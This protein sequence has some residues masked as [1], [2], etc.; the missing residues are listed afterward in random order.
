MVYEK[1]FTIR[2]TYDETTKKA[3]QQILSGTYTE[4]YLQDVADVK[5]EVMYLKGSE[6]KVTVENGEEKYDYSGMKTAKLWTNASVN[7]QS[8]MAYLE[9]ITDDKGNV[10]GYKAYYSIDDGETFEE[11]T[12]SATFEKQST[13]KG[14]VLDKSYSILGA[15]GSLFLYFEYDSDKKCGSIKSDGFVTKKG[16]L[17]DGTEIVAEIGYDSEKGG[18]YLMNEGEITKVMDVD[19]YIYEYGMY[20]YDTLRMSQFNSYE[21]YLQH[22]AYSWGVYDEETGMHTLDKDAVEAYIADKANG[23]NADYYA[24]M[25][26]DD[27]LQDH[28][29]MTRDQ[30]NDAKEKRQEFAILIDEEARSYTEKLSLS[31]ITFTDSFLSDSTGDSKDTDTYSYRILDSSIGINGLNITARMSLNDGQSITMNGDIEVPGG[32]GGESPKEV[33]RIVTEVHADIQGDKLTLSGKD[34]Q[35]DISFNGETKKEGYYTPQFNQFIGGTRLTLTADSHINS[36]NDNLQSLSNSTVDAGTILG[37][38]LSV[39]TN[40]ETVV[41]LKTDTKL[42][43]LAGKMLETNLESGSITVKATYKFNPATINDVKDG[44]FNANLNQELTITGTINGGQ[45]WKGVDVK[46][47]T[48]SLNGIELKN[49]DSVFGGTYNNGNIDMGGWFNWNGT[50]ELNKNISSITINKG[51]FARTCET[52]AGFV[53]SVVGIVVDPI[54]R[55]VTTIVTDIQNGTFGINTVFNAVNDLQTGGLIGGLVNAISSAIDGKGFG[56]GWN[57][58]FSGNVLLNWSASMMLNKSYSQVVADGDAGKAAIMGAVAV[59]AIVVTVCTGGL[60]LAAFI[61]A[62]AAATP[63]LTGAALVASAVITSYLAGT[64]AFNSALAFE[65]GDTLMGVMNAVAA[66]MTILFPVRIGG[67]AEGATAAANAASADKVVVHLSA[68]ERLAAIPNSIVTGLK[69]SVKAFGAL[70]GSQGGVAAFKAWQ[71]LAQHMYSMTKLNVGMNVIGAVFETFGITDAVDKWLGNGGFGNGW[72]GKLGNSVANAVFVES[73]QS[74][75]LIS[76]NMGN[77]VM[78]AGIMYVS[79]PLAQELMSGLSKTFTGKITI[80]AQAPVESLTGFDKFKYNFEHSFLGEQVGGFVEEQVKETVLKHG[81]VSLGMDPAVAEYFVEYLDPSGSVAL[82]NSMYTNFVNN[83]NYNALASSNGS[84]SNVTGMIDS[85]FALNGTT[86]Q[87]SFANNTLTITVNGQTLFISNITNNTSLQNAMLTLA[88][89]A[90]TTDFAK[91][92][93]ATVQAKV[94]AIS[95]SVASLNTSDVNTENLMLALTASVV[96]N[97]DVTA[98]QLQNAYQ[99]VSNYNGFNNLTFSQEFHGATELNLQTKV[100]LVALVSNYANANGVLDSSKIVADINAGNVQAVNAFVQLAVYNNLSAISG[101]AVNISDVMQNLDLSNAEANIINNTV[102]SLQQRFSS[103]IET[104]QNVPGE[105]TAQQRERLVALQDVNEALYAFT[106]GRTTFEQLMENSVVS[107]VIQQETLSFVSNLAYIA[108]IANN[109]KNKVFTLTNEELSSLTTQLETFVDNNSAIL[110]GAIFNL[111][112][113]DLQTLNRGLQA[114]NFAEGSALNTLQQKVNNLIESRTPVSAEEIAAAKVRNTEIQTVLDTATR[115]I[116]SNATTAE[117]QAGKVNELLRGE[118]GKYAA[119]N[120]LMSRGLITSGFMNNAGLQVLVEDILSGREIDINSERYSEY[121]TGYSSDNYMAYLDYNKLAECINQAVMEL[122]GNFR[123]YTG[124]KGYKTEGDNL[125]QYGALLSVLC[126]ANQ[127]IYAEVGFGKTFIADSIGLARSYIGKADMDLIVQNDS[128]LNNHL[129]NKALMERNG[130]VVY[131]MGDIVDAAQN[132]PDSI[133]EFNGEKMTAIE[134]YTRVMNDENGIRIWLDSQYGFGRTTAERNATEQDTR[135]QDVQKAHQARTGR[136]T[137]ADE[138]HKFMETTMSYVMSDGGN[139]TLRQEFSTEQ[140]EAMKQLFA[141]AN[142]LVEGKDFVVDTVNGQVS[143]TEAGM[144]SVREQISGI[145][146]ATTGKVKSMLQAMSEAS[147]GNKYMLTNN[148]ELVGEDAV[149]KLVTKGATGQAEPSMILSDFSYA[150]AA[151]IMCLTSNN[152]EADLRC[153]EEEAIERAFD[154]VRTSH[155]TYG[156]S[157]SGLFFGQGQY[158]GMSGTLSHVA[159]LSD[160]YGMTVTR[161]GTQKNF[162]FGELNIG[163]TRN[164]LEAKLAQAKADLAQAQTTTGA[165]HD[166]IVDAKQKVVEDLTAALQIF[167]TVTNNGTETD[168]QKVLNELGKAMQNKVPGAQMAYEAYNTISLQAFT[169]DNGMIDSNGAISD[170]GIDVIANNIL[171]GSATGM[172]QLFTS[173]RQ[174]TLDKIKARILEIANSENSGYTVSEINGITTI[175]SKTGQVIQLLEINGTTRAD[176]IYKKS[177][178]GEETGYILAE[179]GVTKI[180]LGNERS[181]MGL[182]FS[183]D[184]ALSTDSTDAVYS[185]LHQDFGRVGRH[186]GELFSRTVYANMSEIGTLLSDVE[187][188]GIYEWLQNEFRT[189]SEY[190]K[191]GIFDNIT[192]AED[193]NNLTDAQKLM[194][195]KM[196]KGFVQSS[197]SLMFGMIDTLNDKC[198]T[199][200]IADLMGEAGISEADREV[201]RNV[202]KNLFDNHTDGEATVGRG[203]ILSGKDQI[204]NSLES[205]RQKAIEAFSSLVT[206]LETD[207]AKAKAQQWLE[208]WENA[209]FDETGAANADGS[210]VSLDVDASSVQA[211]FDIIYHQADKVMPY[212]SS[213]ANGMQM[214]K[215]QTQQQLQSNGINET[216]L[217]DILNDNKYSVGENLTYEGVRLVKAYTKLKMASDDDDLARALAILL[218]ELLGLDFSGETGSSAIADNALSIAQQLAKEDISVDNLTSLANMGMITSDN[219]KVYRPYL[220][221]ILKAQY[222]PSYLAQQNIKLPSAMYIEMLKVRNELTTGKLR[223]NETELDRDKLIG[224]IGLN[225]DEQ[226]ILDSYNALTPVIDAA[227]YKNLALS[228]AQRAKADYKEFEDNHPFIAP[229]INDAV[230]VLKQSA[231]FLPTSA[232]LGIINGALGV[233]GGNQIIS[234]SYKLQ[235]QSIVDTIKQVFGM[236]VYNAAKAG[237]SSLAKK[238][239]SEENAQATAKEKKDFIET[240]FTGIEQ[241]KAVLSKI[242]NAISDGRAVKGWNSVY[243]NNIDLRLADVENIMTVDSTELKTR[244]AQMGLPITEETDTAIANMQ[245]YLGSLSD[246]EVKAVRKELRLSDISRFNDMPKLIYDLAQNGTITLSDKE[247]YVLEGLVGSKGV[248][249][250]NNGDVRIGNIRNLMEQTRGTEEKPIDITL[251]TDEEILEIAARMTYPT[252]EPKVFADRYNFVMNNV[253]LDVIDRMSLSVIANGD[254]FVTDRDNK[255]VSTWKGFEEEYERLLKATTIGEIIGIEDAARE[256]RRAADIIETY[257]EGKY[258]NLVSAYRQFERT[259][260]RDRVLEIMKS[261]YSDK[262]SEAETAAYDLYLQKIMDQGVEDYQVIAQRL[263]YNKTTGNNDIANDI[264]RRGI[265]YG[266]AKGNYETLVNFFKNKGIP[267]AEAK[268]LAGSFTLEEMTSETFTVQLQSMITNGLITINPDTEITRAKLYEQVRGITPQQ[269]RDSNLP[270]VETVLEASG[271]DMEIVRDNNKKIFD[272]LSKSALLDELDGVIKFDTGLTLGQLS[273]GTKVRQMMKVTADEYVRDT[274]MGKSYAAVVEEI[275]ERNLDKFVSVMGL[276]KLDKNKE[277]LERV[278]G[279]SLAGRDISIKQHNEIVAKVVGGMSIEELSNSDYVEGVSTLISDG[280][281]SVEDIVSGK[282][283][284]TIIREKK[285]GEVRAALGEEYSTAMT[286]FGLGNVIDNK[287]KLEEKYTSDVE[288]AAISEM[289][290][291]ELTDVEQLISSEDKMKERVT[292]FG[293]TLTMNRAKIISEREGISLAGIINGATRY[294]GYALYDKRAKELEKLG[295]IDVDNLPIKSIIDNGDIVEEVKGLQKLGFEGKDINGILK[296]AGKA[297]KTIR[298]TIQGKSIREF[299]AMMR[300]MS[301][302]QIDKLYEYLG[303]D[304]KAIEKKIREIKNRM[305]VPE[306]L[307][308]EKLT[309]GEVNRSKDIKGLVTK[310]DRRVET[311]NYKRFTIEEYLGLSEQERARYG[312][313]QVKIDARV[314]E[315]VSGEDAILKGYIVGDMSVRDILGEGVVEKKIDRI[316]NSKAERNKYYN[317]MSGEDFMKATEVMRGDKVNKVETEKTRRAILG[318]KYDMFMKNYYSLSRETVFGPVVKKVSVEVLSSDRAKKSIEAVAEDGKLTEE[319]VTKIVLVI[320]ESKEEDSRDREVLG[321]KIKPVLEESQVVSRTD[322]EDCVDV[323][324]ETMGK[325]IPLRALTQAALKATP[326]V[327]DKLK[328]AGVGDTLKGTELGE[329][330]QRTGLSYATMKERDIDLTKIKSKD[331]SEE[332][333][334]VLYMKDTGHAIV[335]TEISDGLVSYKRVDSKGKETEEIK[336]IKE[337]KQEEGSQGIVLSGLKTPFVAY[338]ENEG[339]D[340]GHV[341]TVTEISDGYVT[342]TGT[343]AQGRKIEEMTTVESFFKEEG[344]SGLMLTAKGE[345]EVTYVD[346]GVKEVVGEMFKRAKSNKYGDGKEMLEKIIDGVTAP[347]ELSKAL[348]YVLSIWNKDAASMLEYIGLDESAMGNKEAIVQGATRKITEA[349]ALGKEGKLSEAE[350]RVEIELVTTLRDLLMTV[351]TDKEWLTTAN[352]EEIMAKL[353][354]GKAVNQNVIVNMFEDGVKT[355]VSKASDGDFVIDVKKLQSTIVDKNIKFAKDAKIEDVMELLAGS[356]KKYRTPMMSFSMR[357]IHAIAA[358]A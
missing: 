349:V 29:I 83:A 150:Y 179:E 184:W 152:A 174:D 199:S 194:L 166:Q 12:Q 142:N 301:E 336:S 224:R 212:F 67:G 87:T 254:N 213:A 156:T 197:S 183:G 196:Y 305:G 277:R 61:P 7:G 102:N 239:G 177:E 204:T 272:W 14:F 168:T 153:T 252:Q 350:V 306:G 347:G 343:D 108:D 291:A 342:Y 329:L 147:S 59:A 235:G 249:T 241:A 222:P 358:A 101:V 262:V 1:G 100:N 195:A 316:M 4:T 278:V 130:A 173:V 18:L 143:F 8:A 216:E 322:V 215:T 40:G 271:L 31:D 325:I 32:E 151:T 112:L 356:D 186:N 303:I 23:K 88:T 250:V 255:V 148:A 202:Q 19:E 35:F 134:R 182:D 293:D 312:A 340:I 109:S 125:G 119:L 90:Q 317:K 320:E 96:M 172:N 285:I 324:V 256:F 234:G 231:A 246:K 48:F 46:N 64:A 193:I 331:V 310:V 297:R 189:N 298:E 131:V 178:T 311:A 280:V 136:L 308:M 57:E 5:N 56:A 176:D 201:I 268:K 290:I 62:L 276:E 346:S 345:K 52:V 245:A 264:E 225:A 118:N 137:I 21:E 91:A 55:A 230:S 70:F 121:L 2:I 302:E 228:P 187:T 75:S 27:Y 69:G 84:S 127:G 158:V 229:L 165:L 192:S 139:S 286:A 171:N 323:A 94:N 25:S 351:G 66:V 154:C 9:E 73:A 220:K 114:L 344:F 53:V 223:T 149:G 211:A 284:G 68:A 72:L 163:G 34:A 133:V 104:I 132:R 328:A 233:G 180:I 122:E 258:K 30:F 269:L 191:Y 327:Q 15:D 124:W 129:K 261:P 107:E 126:G 248:S 160:V 20:T 103:E 260:G 334:L 205:Q 243:D 304:R 339:S 157:R 236:Q 123:D 161:F 141:I 209:Q 26:Y 288:K 266:T 115:S 74:D 299:G 287:S 120:F 162:D 332:K 318:D 274:Y 240:V 155:T 319:Q 330:R 244:M 294:L 170:A 198:V 203:E 44:N 13:Y 214:T 283:I 185:F 80:E 210:I 85:M 86:A 106:E 60:G 28:G 16:T 355:S 135:L 169:T 167:D 338:M 341:V 314:R 200:A 282:A 116:G 273:D 352:E 117:E 333:P 105:L 47:K 33:E 98:S 38:D 144:R 42:Y 292:S 79:M 6:L 181:G 82:T 22:L 217:M 238:D 289:S 58:Y 49:G 146:D 188:A 357:N 337:F 263:A 315:L 3:T 159:T 307:A 77:S 51:W 41:V 92:D 257:G 353:I 270:N 279:E 24:N 17:P 218:G 326:Y 43:A 206:L 208:A 128:E 232:V 111:N 313:D 93:M 242:P 259:V 54:V 175:T 321:E 296:E 164:S 36:T 295:E 219:V 348:K 71:G 95:E 140:Q 81:L 45:S 78:F 309:I 145:K 138:V 11:Y 267:E 300:G 10:I 237:I 251:P 354:V 37:Q 63:A 97:G 281:I 221:Q 190:S 207:A 335:V 275:G 113:S 247:K 39:T 99:I 76:V 265:E 89:V 227:Q 110:S 65:K 226:K 253:E 50:I